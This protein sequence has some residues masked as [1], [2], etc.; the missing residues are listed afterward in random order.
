MAGQ[1]LKERRDAFDHYLNSA[2]LCDWYG[3]RKAARRLAKAG[4]KAYPPGKKGHHEVRILESNRRRDHVAS[5]SGERSSK[6]V[7]VRNHCDVLVIGAGPS[8]FWHAVTATR[9]GR[10]VT[11]VE[12]GC[13]LGGMWTGIV[14][15]VFDNRHHDTRMLNCGAICSGSHWEA[16]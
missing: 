16:Y 5:S 6:S 15:P 12:Y 14:E 13:K 1:G 9:R 3:Y 10:K 11:L 8:W 4:L 2:L 7:E